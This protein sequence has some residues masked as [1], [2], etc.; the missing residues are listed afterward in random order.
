MVPLKVNGPGLLAMTRRTPGTGSSTTSGASSRFLSKGMSSFIYPPIRLR[1]PAYHY[2]GHDGLVNFGFG[3]CAEW[4][5]KIEIAAV[6]GL[7][8][9]L[10]IKCAIAARIPW[11]RLF[12]VGA[13]SGDF[14]V[15][16]MEMDAARRHV[17]L[18]LVACFHEGK[19]AA[20]ETLGRHMQNAG[21][22]AGAAHAR[23][24]NTQHVAHALLHQLFRDRQHAPLRHPRPALRP[25]VLEHEN[26]V[27]RHVEVVALDLAC[28]VVVVLEGEHLAAMFEQP[29]FS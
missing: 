7:P 10:R 5:E 14:F 12:P 23:I 4:C 2:F 16:H 26:V 19:R 9:V 20:D 25:A 13:A 28:H 6:I 27:G 8:D 1:E 17:N 11:R 18:D 22:V 24:G 21:A 29:F 3:Y 15:R